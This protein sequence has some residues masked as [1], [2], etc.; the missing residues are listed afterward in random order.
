MTLREAIVAKAKEYLG[1]PYSQLDCSAF[2]RQVFR[3]FDYELPRVSATQA[4]AMY[5]KGYGV[6]I[7]KAETVENILPLLKAG[8]IMWWSHPTYPTRWLWIHHVGLYIGNGQIIDSAGTGVK[9]RAL[10]ETSKWQIVMISDIT[11]LLKWEGES[12]GEE[13]INKDSNIK[14]IAR[15]QQALI[16]IGFGGDMN[17]KYLGQWGT[18]TEGAVKLF[19]KFIGLPQT[20]VIG[21]DTAA[22]LMDALGDF[23]ND[24]IADLEA[25]VNNDKIAIRSMVD[26]GNG[27]L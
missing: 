19:Q 12:E 10:W 24:E 26:I 14:T 7:E 2:V 16:T 13:V 4:K 11:S 23:F 21:A 18:K 25:T 15:A 3:A 6:K 9:Q 20:G 17:P 27:R 22:A 8:D 5:D 1:T